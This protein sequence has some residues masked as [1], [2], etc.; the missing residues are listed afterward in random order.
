MVPTN[1]GTL[2]V[3]VLHYVGILK[4]LFFFSTKIVP[5]DNIKIDDDS[6]SDDIGFV[7]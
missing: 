5:L 1:V 7:Y 4:D 2:V 6:F 3:T